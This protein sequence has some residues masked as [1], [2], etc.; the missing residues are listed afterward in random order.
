MKKFQKKI[1]LKTMKKK[2]EKLR[3]K[4][5]GKRDDEEDEFSG[6]DSDDP[7][8]GEMHEDDNVDSDDS[9]VRFWEQKKHSNI[10]SIIIKK[11]FRPLNGSLPKNK[12]RSE[13]WSKN[14]WNLSTARRRKNWQKTRNS[15]SDSSNLCSKHGHFRITKIWYSKLTTNFFNYFYFRKKKS[16]PKR[17]KI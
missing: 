14:V 5:K 1:T 11:Y 4:N 9:E 7:M 3:K 17:V 2:A 8:D 16:A 6:G 13:H 10:Y 12:R 15:M